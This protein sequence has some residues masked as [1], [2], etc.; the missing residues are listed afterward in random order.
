MIAFEGRALLFEA[1]IFDQGDN[2]FVEIVFNRVGIGVDQASRD[3][4]LGACRICPEGYI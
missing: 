3:T 4:R 1:G 2:L